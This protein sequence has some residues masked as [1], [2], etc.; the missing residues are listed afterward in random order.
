MTKDDFKFDINAKK[1]RFPDKDLIE[2]LEAYARL[3]NNEYFSTMNM[4]SGMEKLHIL[5][6]SLI[7]SV[8]GIRRSG[9]L[10]LRAGVKENTQQRS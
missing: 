4:I 1:V 6:H 5:K 3:K 7:D 8:L 9:L 10:V 2:S